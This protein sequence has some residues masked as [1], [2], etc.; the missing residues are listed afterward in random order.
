[1]T[2]IVSNYNEAG[3]YHVA[4]T[5][6]DGDAFAQEHACGRCAAIVANKQREFRRKARAFLDSAMNPDAYVW[7]VLDEAPRAIAHEEGR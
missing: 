5:A 4:K 2:F 6:P 7:E 1:M 3:I